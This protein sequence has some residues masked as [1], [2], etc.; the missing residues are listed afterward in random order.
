[1]VASEI[2]ALGIKHVCDGTPYDW[3]LQEYAAPAKAGVTFDLMQENPVAAPMTAV[4]TAE[5][6]QR[7]NA[8]GSMRTCGGLFLLR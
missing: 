3:A 2:A 5:D 6:V 1:M 4:G 7:D 8:L